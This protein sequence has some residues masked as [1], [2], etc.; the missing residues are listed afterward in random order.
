MDRSRSIERLAAPL[1]RFAAQTSR[2]VFNDDRGLDLIAMLTTR[3]RAARTL[4]AAISKQTI[5]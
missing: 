5:H 3:P 2:Q 4:H 1:A